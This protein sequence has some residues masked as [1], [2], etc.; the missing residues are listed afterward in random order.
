MCRDE[1]NPKSKSR[2][3]K[4]ARKPKAESRSL[5]PNRAISLSPGSCHSFGLRISDFGFPQ[6]MRYLV[7]ARVKAGRE[8][9]LLRAINARTLGRGSVAGDEYLYDMEQARVSEDGA[10]HWVE[11]C[12]C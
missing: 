5:F 1:R 11:T 2:N 8:R 6:H 4:E 9:D 10:A 7:K 12:F 3:P